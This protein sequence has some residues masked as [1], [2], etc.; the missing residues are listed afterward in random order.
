MRPLRSAR[1]T[2]STRALGSMSRC[3]SASHSPGRKP[4]A[5]A[6]INAELGG[7]D[8]EYPPLDRAFEHLP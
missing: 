8:V 7:V 6:R 3:S 1:R 4:V 5:A 2:W